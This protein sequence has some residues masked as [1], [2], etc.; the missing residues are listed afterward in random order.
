MASKKLPQKLKNLVKITIS[1][2]GEVIEEQAGS[3]F[4]QVSG[5]YQN[6]DDEISYAKYVPSF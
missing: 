3:D 4:F 2:L 1:L 6:H 5:R